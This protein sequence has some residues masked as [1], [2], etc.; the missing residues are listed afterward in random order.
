MKVA[1][2]CR[3]MSRHATVARHK[4]NIF[5]PNT[6]RHAKV[7]RQMENVVG[8]NRTRAMIERATHR[9][10][11][12]HGRKRRTTTEGIRKWSSLGTRRN[13]KENLI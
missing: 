6:T 9:V 11:S 8:R 1:A 4:K 7:A 2:A 12:L 5:R 13:T 10:G 3:K